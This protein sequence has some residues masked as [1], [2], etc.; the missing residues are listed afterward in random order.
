MYPCCL[1]KPPIVTTTA[2]LTRPRPPRNKRTRRRYSC[3]QRTI[4]KFVRRP[5][6][7]SFART[8]AKTGTYT[9]S[10]DDVCCLSTITPFCYLRHSGKCICEVCSRDK[11]RIPKMDD[12]KLFRVCNP[13]GREL[14]NQRVYGMQRQRSRS[15]E[16]VEATSSPDRVN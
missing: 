13:C 11:M 5:S 12:H 3:R 7:S 8:I 15:E 16:E 2:H 10:Y 1:T 9:F 6:H 14:K 4:A